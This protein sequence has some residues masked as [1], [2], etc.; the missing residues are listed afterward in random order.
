MSAALIRLR[1][2]PVVAASNSSLGLAAIRTLCARPQAPSGVPA[3][4]ASTS[5]SA[6]RAPSHTSSTPG[7]ALPATAGVPA[8]SVEAPAKPTL[9]ATV[10]KWMWRGTMTAAGAAAAGGVALY[11]TDPEG[12]RD[13]AMQMRADVEERVRFFTEPSR[14]KL[15]PDPVPPFPGAQPLRTLV[16]ELEDTL[17]HSSYNRNFGWRVAK[18]PGAEAFLAYMSSFYEIVIFTSGLSSYADPILNKLDPNKYYVSYRLYRAETKYEAG[19][20]VKD[21]AHLNRDMSRVILVDND[22]AH[23]KYQP[24][25]AIQIP[26]WSDDPDDTAL[27]DLIP[28]LEELVHDDVVDVRDEVSTLTGKPLR[29]GIAEHRALAL[30]RAERAA[31]ATRGS[32]FGAPLPRAAPV[33]AAA[34][35]VQPAT[36]GSG[37]D[38]PGL[39]SES[40]HASGVT[41]DTGKGKKSVWGSVSKSTGMFRPPQHSSSAP[42]AADSD[43]AAP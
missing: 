20:H 36:D 3:V 33:P 37:G 1:L 27:L 18:R 24:E 39:S 9:A 43:P 16:I 32:L 13:M 38:Y 7:A 42:A 8:A 34:L 11:A 10:S 17:V 2:P 25:N 14:E 30:S 6:A 15:L 22:P 21:L 28:F 23:F 26:K 4:T 29:T 35:L 5:A 40:P 19:V 12:S 41:L 31:S